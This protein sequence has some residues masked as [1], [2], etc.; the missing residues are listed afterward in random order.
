MRTSSTTSS[1]EDYR[2][3]LDRVLREIKRQLV[4]RAGERNPRAARQELER[5]L[6]RWYGRNEAHVRK[7]GDEWRVDDRRFRT[8]EAARDYADGWNAGRSSV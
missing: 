3:E 1:R 7:D 2:R 6:S 4:R 5:F 8:R